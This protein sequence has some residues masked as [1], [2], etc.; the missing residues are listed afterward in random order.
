MNQQRVPET[1]EEARLLAF[2]QEPETWA[3]G[4]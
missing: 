1:S 3:R 4:T 2:A